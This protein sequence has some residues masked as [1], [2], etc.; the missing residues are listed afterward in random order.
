MMK[1]TLLALTAGAALATAMPLAASAAD[2]WVGIN[3]RQAKLEQRI[4]EGVRSGSLTKDEAAGIRAEYNHIADLEA[5]YRK[6]GGGLSAEERADLD[7]RFD[8]LS[9]RIHKQK[10]DTQTA[11][12][13]GNTGSNWVGINQRQAQ[14]EERIDQGIRS[15]SLTKQEASGI[16]EQYNHL[17]SL[18][19]QYR[20]SGGGLSAEERADLDRRFDALSDRIYKQKHDTQTRSH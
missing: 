20:S 1:R 2:N 13:T 10:H 3:Q 16:R 8:A 18:E 7:R 6:S 14:L 19:A 11:S 9:D 12:N 4:D 15:G 5:Q 17:A